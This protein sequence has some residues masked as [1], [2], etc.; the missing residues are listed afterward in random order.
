MLKQ[1]HWDGGRSEIAFLPSA[2]TS[3]TARILSKRLR[4]AAFPF[5]LDYS[6]P[7]GVIFHFPHLVR[8]LAGKLR[9]R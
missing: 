2:V 6:S 4:F 7:Q 9:L 3:P 5:I 1:Q 8:S